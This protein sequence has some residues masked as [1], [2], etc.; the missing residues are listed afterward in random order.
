MFYS[1]I[2]IIPKIVLS[3]KPPILK[4]TEL[5]LPGVARRATQLWQ[6]RENVWGILESQNK[7]GIL[8]NSKL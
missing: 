4:I 3:R 5:L 2:Y 7:A 6:T 1:S 8:M